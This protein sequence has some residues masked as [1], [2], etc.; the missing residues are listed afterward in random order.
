LRGSTAIEMSPPQRSWPF[1]ATPVWLNGKESA[2]AT[3]RPASMSEGSVSAENGVA[4]VPQLSSRTTIASAL[5]MTSVFPG[6]LPVDA[7]QRKN[8]A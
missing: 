5:V 6:K 8:A 3:R 7:I 4:P 1:A 2:V